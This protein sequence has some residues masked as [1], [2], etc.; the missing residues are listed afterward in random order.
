MG[1]MLNED[2]NH[3]VYTRA[4]AGIDVGRKELDDF[5]YQYKDT[6]VTDFFI[7]VSGSIGWYPCKSRDNAIDCYHRALEIGR[8]VRLG[9][10]GPDYVKLLVDIYE[11]KGLQMHKIWVERCREIGINPWISIRANDVHNNDDED[12]FLH[13]SFFRDNRDLRRGAHHVATDYFDNALD[14]C[15]PQVRRHLLDMVTE[16]V[17]EFDMY[18]L[19]ID[20]MR[21]IY[22]LRI[23]REYE[24]APLLTQLMAD[25]RAAADE[26]EKKWGHPIKI[27]I[28]LPADPV[29]TMRLGFDFIEWVDRGLVD[30][31]TVCPRWATSD[32]DMA[33]DVYKKILSGRNVQLAAGAE[34]LLD[35]MFTE[36]HKEIMFNSPQT[37]RGT[38][39]AYLSMGAQG[40]YLFNYMDDP[41]GG[42]MIGIPILKGDSYLQL[43]SENGSLDT[44]GDKPRRHV[45]TYCDVKSPGVAHKNPLPLECSYRGSGNPSFT[46]KPEY[47]TLRIPTGEIPRGAVLRLV[48]GVDSDANLE[49]ENFDVFV[50]ACPANFEKC[51][52]LPQPSP[53]A[54][55]YYSFSVDA[56]EGFAPVSIVEIGTK[57]RPFTVKWA[58]IAVNPDY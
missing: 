24:G 36:P 2:C 9:V 3:F 33:F 35:S 48:L 21:E 26:A 53:K 57:R 47:K 34:I 29:L 45:V 49:P 5:I 4:S 27:A 23:G 28:R 41:S 50:N 51:V 55:R 17:N 6:Q 46:G 20:W 54:L 39:A 30:L 40:V 44:I 42:E 12:N 15:H 32:N 56:A 16:V 58:E 52:K 19:E 13:S 7:N 11:K 8:E 38:A 25:V 43:L 37:V 18:G 1:I 22:S 10:N 31:I 14:F